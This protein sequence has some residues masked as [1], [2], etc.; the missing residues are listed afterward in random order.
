MV[1][2]RGD[3]VVGLGIPVCRTEHEGGRARRAAFIGV[4]G[5][6]RAVKHIRILRGQVLPHRRLNR[7]GIYPVRAERQCGLHIQPCIVARRTAV[8]VD[9]PLGERHIARRL[10]AEPQRD[11]ITVLQLRD[12]ARRFRRI[13][14]THDI[15]SRR[16]RDGFAAGL[17][18]GGKAVIKLACNTDR[19]PVAIGSLHAHVHGRA[20]V[21]EVQPHNGLIA[22]LGDRCER[23]YPADIAERDR[24]RIVRCVQRV[25]RLIVKAI[26]AFR[27][28]RPRKAGI[29]IQPE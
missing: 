7:I 18:R 26:R 23:R 24:S 22:A 25:E 15:L 17:C 28:D 9:V 14:R 21:G 12:A 2:G 27:N 11:S 1:G 5:G 3:G 8:D 29:I 4:V 19:H 13:D 10:R 6:H 20:A 16:E